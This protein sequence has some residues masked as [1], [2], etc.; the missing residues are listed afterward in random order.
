MAHPS[1]PVASAVPTARIRREELG[2]PVEVA[3]VMTGAAV[4][5]EDGRGDQPA[6]RSLERN[7]RGGEDVCSIRERLALT[8]NWSKVQAFSSRLRPDTVQL[9]G[10]SYPAEKYTRET[11][12]AAYLHPEV[13]PDWGIV[14]SYTMRQ[15]GVTLNAR[16]EWS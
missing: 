13:A 7:L 10:L 4:H 3:Q 14:P 15:R 5:S 1:L 2:L 16:G 8:S 12:Q 9:K 11:R 6:I